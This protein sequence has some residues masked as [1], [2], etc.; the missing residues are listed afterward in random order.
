MLV[1][2]KSKTVVGSFL[3]K[4]ENEIDE[5]KLTKH[6]RRLLAALEKI[7]LVTRVVVEEPPESGTQVLAEVPV[8]PIKKRVSKKKASG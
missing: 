2:L 7:K 1:R 6:R 3:R 4:G 5:D 8:R